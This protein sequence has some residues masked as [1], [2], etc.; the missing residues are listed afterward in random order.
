MPLNLIKTYPQLLEI[1][2][3][4]EYQRNQS[5]QGVFNR[6]FVDNANL[7]FKDKQIRPTKQ[8]GEPPMQTLFR[9]LTTREDKDG[10]GKKLGSRSFEMTRSVRLHWIKHHINELKKGNVEVFS[11][12]DRID[13]KDV[14]RTYIYDIDQEYVIILEPQRSGT[15]YYLLTAYHLNEPGGKKQ[16]EKKRKKKLDEVY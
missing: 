6:D 16:I 3:M 7:K 1:A 15:D 11:Y 10:K 8:D 9:H 12:E 13:R 5:L 4:N 2:H 14:I